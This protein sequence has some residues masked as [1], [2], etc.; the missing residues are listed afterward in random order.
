MDDP[1]VTSPAEQRRAPRRALEVPIT[2]TVE[3]ATVRGVTDNVSGV[4]LMF[5]ADEPLRVR[6][7]FADSDGT[8]RVHTGR[9][10][11]TQKMT[12]RTTGFAIEFDP[13]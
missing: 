12:E 5:F 9:L 11:R 2:L 13:E 8:V 3:N 10:V 4:G 1:P 6:V 7:E